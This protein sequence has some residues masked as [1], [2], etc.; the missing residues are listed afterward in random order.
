MSLSDRLIARFLDTNRVPGVR[1]RRAFKSFPAGGSGMSDPMT[2]RG[3]CIVRNASN[4][5]ARLALPANN[6]VLGSNGSD[7]I[8]I[9]R[10]ASCRAT[11]SVG[12]A[13]PT[14]S[15]V[16]VAFGAED[17]DNGGLHD[18]VTNNSRITVP[19]GGAGVY[20]I[21]AGIGWPAFGG[22]GTITLERIRLNGVTTIADH[23][24]PSTI[25]ATGNQGI[26]TTVWNAAV[27]D[28][29]ETIVYHENGVDLTIAVA[30]TFFSAALLVAQ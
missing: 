23:G 2:T 30:T 26:V 24:H 25:G 13:I 22:T 29:F 15:L 5:T 11:K 19:T 8:G 17:Y 7:L 9:G 12:Q 20:L 14:A 10:Q 27:G 6:G 1:G 18:T 3:D 28:Y 16:A 21:S 4:V